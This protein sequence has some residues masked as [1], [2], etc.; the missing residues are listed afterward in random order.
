MVRKLPMFQSGKLP[1]ETGR[2]ALTGRT[3][4]LSYCCPKHLASLKGECPYYCSC[5]RVRYAKGFLG[6]LERLTAKQ[7]SIVNIFKECGVTFPIEFDVYFENYY[8]D[9]TL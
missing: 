1:P 9:N 8:W 4:E 3:L 2:K 6:I 5:Q 7:Q